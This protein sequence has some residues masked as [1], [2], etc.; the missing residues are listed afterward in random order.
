[1]LAKLSIYVLLLFILSTCGIVFENGMVLIFIEV[2]YK[3]VL[4]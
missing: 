1:M 2:M 4:S 3:C